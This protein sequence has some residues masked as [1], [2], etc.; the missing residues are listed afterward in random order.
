M[1]S[2]VLIYCTDLRRLRVL[3]S[4][5]SFHRFLAHISVLYSWY[6]GV[7]LDG[8]Q[9]VHETAQPSVVTVTLPGE[10]GAWGLRCMY[11]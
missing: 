5:N 6:G 11:K 4:D 8:D 3:F 1:M 2:T 7:L 10:R 9:G